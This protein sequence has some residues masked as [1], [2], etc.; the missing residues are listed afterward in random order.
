MIQKVTWCDSIDSND[1]RLLYITC[2]AGMLYIKEY[3][4]VV[5]TLLS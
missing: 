1:I 4:C 2:R 5:D 3:K